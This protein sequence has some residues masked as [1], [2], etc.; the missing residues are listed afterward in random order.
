MKE[1]AFR[2]AE[3]KRS[4]SLSGGLKAIYDAAVETF[5]QNALDVYMDCPT[6]ER[7][8]WL[9]DSFLPPEWNICLRAPAVWKKGVF[10]E[11]YSA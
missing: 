5:R 1:Y 11:F 6:R 8:G 3:I 7:A 10:R 9:C 4:L 2:A